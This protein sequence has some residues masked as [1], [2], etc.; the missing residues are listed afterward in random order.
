MNI[1]ATMCTYGVLFTLQNVLALRSFAAVDGHLKDIQPNFDYFPFNSTIRQITSG[2]QGSILIVLVLLF[3]LAVAGTIF[4]KFVIRSRVLAGI[5]FSV[6][7]LIVAAAGLIAQ[8]G[9]FI[10]WG[11]NINFNFG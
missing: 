7:I 5:G 2:V 4:S 11:S 9:G 3:I 1:I 8:A 6:I 10:D